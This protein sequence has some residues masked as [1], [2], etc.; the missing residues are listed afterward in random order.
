[1]AWFV[2]TLIF[3]TILD[4]ITISRKPTLDKDL[5]I[6][7]LRLIY[8][9]CIANSTPPIRPSRIEKLTLSALQISTLIVLRPGEAI[10]LAKN[11]C[12]PL[13]F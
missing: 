5:E 11:Q 13:I 10:P 1:M 12:K 3:S 6:L 9:F 4:I 7:V 8:Q 2:I